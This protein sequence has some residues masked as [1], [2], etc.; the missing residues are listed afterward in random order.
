MNFVVHQ[1]EDLIKELKYYKS[2][3]KP[4]ELL[5]V[6]SI[7]S[8]DRISKVQFEKDTKYS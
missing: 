6:F 2:E 5:K 3:G 7:P 1:F 4:K 8:E